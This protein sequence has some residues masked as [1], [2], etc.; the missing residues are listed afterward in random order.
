M[1]N[2]RGLSS[3]IGTIIMIALV[4]VVGIIVWAGVNGL[5]DGK[6]DGAGSCVDIMEKISLNPEYTC[7]TSAVVL[8]SINKESAAIDSI[9]VKISGGGTTKS[10]IL[11]ST[12]YDV[13]ALNLTDYPLN[14]G[15]EKMPENNTGY[16]Y[17]YSGFAT[18]PSSVSVE[19][20]PVIGSRQ[21]DAVDKIQQIP[22]CS[23]LGL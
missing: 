23:I 8:F 21:C 17:N 1:E 4:F 7:R 6:L 5:I 15:A 11:N 22:D 20:A 16:T 12:D 19:I 9:V 13:G 18:V 3:I 14:D 10:I 2:K